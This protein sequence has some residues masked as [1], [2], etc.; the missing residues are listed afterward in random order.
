MVVRMDRRN[1]LKNAVASAVML[2]SSRSQAASQAA[3]ARA[4]TQ[5]WT[6]A[7]GQRPAP[8]DRHFRSEIVETYIRETAGRIGDPG[9]RRL[10]INCFSNTLDT[11]VFPGEF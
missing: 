1:F 5:T 4:I 2:P 3:P 6:A 10:F 7:S 8:A 9:L 11:T